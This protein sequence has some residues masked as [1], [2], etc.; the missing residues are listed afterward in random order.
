MSTI[1]L[2]EQNFEATVQNGIVFL[3]W[4]AAWCQPCRRFAPVYE[5]ASERYP[6]ATWGKVDT[7]AQQGLAGA[8]QIQSIPTL[9]IFRDGILLFRQPGMLPAEALD[10]LYE[11]AAALD[12]DVVRAEVEKR[13]AEAGEV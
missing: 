8:F 1:E 5:A 12:M 13:K 9:M 11:K 7:E 3:D 4:W 6:T 10:E 2:T